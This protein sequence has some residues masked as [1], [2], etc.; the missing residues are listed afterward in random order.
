MIAFMLGIPV[1]CDGPVL[2][3][4]RALRAPVLV[5]A[6]ALSRWRFEVGGW[7]AWN[8]F[9]TRPLRALT[10]L[11]AHLDSAGF[12]AAVRYGAFPWAVVRYMDLCAAFPWRWFA[13]MDLCVEPEV[14]HD[15]A[16]ILNRVARTAR[17]ARLCMRQARDRGIAE[18]LLPVIQGWEPRHYLRCLDM[19]PALD[20]YPV[21]GVGSMCRRHV[22]GPTGAVAVVEALDRA[23][24][25]GVRL[26][27]FGV[28]TD[29]AEALRGHHRIASVDSQAYGMHARQEAR[30]G[31]FS[32]SNA[33]LAGVMAEWWQAQLERL[34]R[35][36]WRETPSQDTLDLAPPP[37]ACP[38]EQRIEA[39]LEEMRELVAE[40][41]MPPSMLRLAALQ[42]AYME[43]DDDGD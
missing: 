3:T 42:W 17:L 38:V 7:R 26:H 8:G 28:K 41:E 5:S 19:M 37:P 10:G 34:A 43:D 35:P 18:R 24:P 39:A 36:G 30:K 1:V 13:S 14:A 25:P 6:N 12:V 40:D 27:L 20:G 16:E 21:I 11:D 23:L 9:A 2:R 32:K 31:G 33:Y 22:R 15:E 29:A 4:A